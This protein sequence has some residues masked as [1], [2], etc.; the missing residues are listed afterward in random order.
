MTGGKTLNSAF[1][2]P[3]ALARALCVYYIRDSRHNDDGYDCNCANSPS[4]R[5]GIAISWLTAPQTRPIA[6]ATL[7]MGPIRELDCGLARCW[8]LQ[9]HTMLEVETRDQTEARPVYWR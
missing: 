6:D 9:V 5:V 4:A 7:D 1:D 2:G 3:S 8:P